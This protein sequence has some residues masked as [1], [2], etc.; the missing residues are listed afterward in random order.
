VKM[1]EGAGCRER[2]GVRRAPRFEQPPSTGTGG[3][4]MVAL[5]PAIANAIFDANGIRS[6]SLPML[7]DGRLTK[8]NTAA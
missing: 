6:R 1:G 4:P 2:G 3:T 7:P 5:A 8:D